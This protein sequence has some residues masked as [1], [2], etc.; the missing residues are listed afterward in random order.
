MWQGSQIGCSLATLDRAYLH[1]GARHA[2]AVPGRVTSGIYA[3]QK[4]TNYYYLITAISAA[5]QRQPSN[6]PLGQP[7]RTERHILPGW[8]VSSACEFVRPLVFVFVCLR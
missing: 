7:K 2:R 5:G 8:G 3:K 4:K 1:A 6:Q